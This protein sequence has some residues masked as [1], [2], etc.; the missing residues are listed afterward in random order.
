MAMHNEGF[1]YAII[2][3]VGPIEFYQKTVQATVIENEG[4]SL[5]D[6]FYKFP[7]D[8]SKNGG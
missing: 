5:Y 4:A 2:G 1:Q 3:G 8:K 6:D 7:T